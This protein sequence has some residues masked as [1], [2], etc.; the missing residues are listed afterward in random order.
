[1]TF[2]ELKEDIEKMNNL[3][4]EIMEN[5]DKHIKI[6]EDHIIELRSIIETYILKKKQSE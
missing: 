6:L 3:H 5:K 1:M 4:E 2:E